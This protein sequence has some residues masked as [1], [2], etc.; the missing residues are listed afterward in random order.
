MRTVKLLEDNTGSIR[1]KC[2]INLYE[3]GSNHGFLD[4]IAKA[5]VTKKNR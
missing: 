2:R 1:R 3:F 4:L 5:W